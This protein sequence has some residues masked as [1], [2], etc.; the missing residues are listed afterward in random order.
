MGAIGVREWV[1]D[2][3]LTSTGSV[4]VAPPL[5]VFGAAARGTN[6]DPGGIAG[7]GFVLD[8]VILDQVASLEAEV[9]SCFS[10]GPFSSAVLT[11]AK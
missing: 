3:V 9:V 10:P 5:N 1:G 6:K 4:Q 8:L 7:V 2:A 11:A